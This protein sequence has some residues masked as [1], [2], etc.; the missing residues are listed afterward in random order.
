MIFQFQ[1]AV[2]VIPALCLCIYLVYLV[3]TKEG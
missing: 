2:I 3:E 1:Q